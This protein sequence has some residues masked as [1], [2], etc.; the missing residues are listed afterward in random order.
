MAPSTQSVVQPPANSLGK[1][2]ASAEVL[3]AMQAYADGHQVNEMLRLLLTRLLEE[4][5]LDPIEFLVH[6]VRDSEPLDALEKRCAAQRFDLRREKTK[7]KLVANV[8][9]RLLALQA[10]STRKDGKVDMDTLGG[11]HLARGFLMEQL[12][13]VETRGQLRELFPRHYRDLAQWFRANDKQLPQRIDAEKFTSMCLQV[14]ATKA[15]AS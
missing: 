13:A 2:A 7:R 8:F 1:A 5:P 11:Q 10:R 9:N 3:E 14:L 4:Q 6:A 15:S 12:R